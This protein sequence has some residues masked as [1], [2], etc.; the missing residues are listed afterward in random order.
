MLG[1]DL[2]R[3]AVSGRQSPE[4]IA[5][6]FSSEVEHMQAPLM[7]QGK[8]RGEL[9]CSQGCGFIPDTRVCADIRNFPKQCLIVAHH[10]FGLRVDSNQAGAIRKDALQC[11][12]IVHQQITRGRAHE[13]FDSTDILNGV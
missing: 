4:Q 7:L 3:N 10:G 8:P 1:T 6:F 13:N 12:G 2:G 9:G 5:F 11:H